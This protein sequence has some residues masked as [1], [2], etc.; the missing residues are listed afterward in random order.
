MNTG[1]KSLRFENFHLNILLEVY[2]EIL[3]KFLNFNYLSPV[4]QVNK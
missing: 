2:V 4:K 3:I 1:L